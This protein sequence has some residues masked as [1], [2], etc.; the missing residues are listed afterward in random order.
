M[1]A[2]PRPTPCPPRSNRSTARPM[3]SSPLRSRERSLRA[4][5]PH[6]SHSE[7]RHG[8][9]S[10][11]VGNADQAGWRAIDVAKSGSGTQNTLLRA[12]P[13]SPCSWT[14]F[15]PL[16]G[17]VMYNLPPEKLHADVGM[18][19]NKSPVKRPNDTAAEKTMS[20]VGKTRFGRDLRFIITRCSPVLL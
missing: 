7:S 8:R 5:L 16:A 20:K 18:S 17:H 4:T 9:R 15:L 12:I 2:L 10:S 14:H 19:L 6:L 3:T 13:R 11:V 1:P